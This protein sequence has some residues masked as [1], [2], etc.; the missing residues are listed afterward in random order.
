MSEKKVGRPSIVRDEVV[1]KLEQ[2]FA[3]GATDTEACSF[4]GISRGTL[5]NYIQ[6]N[7]TFLD[8]I[9]ELKSKLPLRA[10]FELKQLVE[11][12]NEKAIFWY[13]DRLQKSRNLEG[14]S[15]LADAVEETT[16]EELDRL[17]KIRS[18]RE[19]ELDRVAE[20][21]YT[22]AQVYHIR[23]RIQAEGDILFSDKTGATYT[24]PLQN[25]LLALQNRMD[26]LRDKLFPSE[27]QQTGKM[28]RDIRDDFLS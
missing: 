7:P 27:Q 28:V 20:Y 11:S 4:A 19:D 10:K 3:I 26:K 25:Q 21:A 5:Y 9:S 14:S 24:N 17:H 22:L 1:Q 16:R 18:Y 2:A 8:R 6:K 13:L 12:G 23:K 15:A